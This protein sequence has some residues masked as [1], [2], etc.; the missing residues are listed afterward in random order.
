MS[1]PAPFAPDDIEHLVY[2]AL[3]QIGW[4]TDAKRLASRLVRLHAGLPREDEFAVVCTWLGRCPLIHK[5]DQSQ[6]PTGSS[7]LY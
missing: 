6:A 4:K 5:L 7:S 3:S 2:E 1:L